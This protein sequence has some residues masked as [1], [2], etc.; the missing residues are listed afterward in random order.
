MATCSF[1]AGATILIGIECLGATSDNM[2]GVMC[3]AAMKAAVETV[4]GWAV[5]P[6]SAPV[7]AT[8]TAE[9]RAISPQVGPGWDLT[10]DTA[11]PAA[12]AIGMY[13]TNA[14]LTLPSGLV[15]KTGPLFLQI[16]Q[17]TA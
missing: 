14:V 2:I 3:A 8:F 7:V 16:V 11:T 1:A 5:P 4:D 13:V 10:I 15:V 12:L 9:P 6:A 17:A